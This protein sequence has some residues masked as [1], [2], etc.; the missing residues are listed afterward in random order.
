MKMSMSC[1]LT[2][3]R[4]YLSLVLVLTK[5]HN[6]PLFENSLD[7]FKTHHSLLECH[8][9]GILWHHSQLHDGLLAEVLVG[10]GK[11][12]VSLDHSSKEENT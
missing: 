12:S 9:Y 7:S 2:W 4:F 3:S 5:I 11:G 1:T 6:F 10:P 8:Q